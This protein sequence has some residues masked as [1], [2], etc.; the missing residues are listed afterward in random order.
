[1]SSNSFHDLINL[2]VVHYSF[3]LTRRV[4]TIN[5]KIHATKL[6]HFIK[7]FLYS[8]QNRDNIFFSSYELLRALHK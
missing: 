1:M 8:I 2:D 3:E 4:T 6:N 5:N 7:F